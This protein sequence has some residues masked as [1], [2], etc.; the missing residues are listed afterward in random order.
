MRFNNAHAT[1]LLLECSICNSFNDVCNFLP[2]SIEFEKM[3][4][5]AMMIGE[6]S[7]IG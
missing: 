3:L 2:K 4:N 6:T 5:L 7:A 1:G